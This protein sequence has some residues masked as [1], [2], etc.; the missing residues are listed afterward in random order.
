MGIDDYRYID[1]ELI[2]MMDSRAIYD[3]KSRSR[4]SLLDAAKAG[5]RAT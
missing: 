2:L 1:I 5:G 3:M 4:L